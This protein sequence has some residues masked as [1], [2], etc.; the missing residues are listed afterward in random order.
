MAAN[1][2]EIYSLLPKT[3]CK[4]CGEPTCMAFATAL[5]MHKRELEDCTPLFEE[6]KY[7][8]QKEK[9]QEII[10]PITGALETGFV[11]HAEKCSGCGNC[12]VACPVNV[13]EDENVAR[14]RGPANDRVIIRVADGTVVDVDIQR[15]RRFGPERTLC[16]ACID[17]CAY[18]AIEFVGI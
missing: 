10:A 16:S 2:L 13:V 18:K 8:K 3:N 17:T 5:L 4:K 11:I 9:L 1:A 14:G 12:V 15:C 7:E 6:A